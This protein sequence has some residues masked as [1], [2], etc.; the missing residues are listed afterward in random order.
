MSDFLTASLADILNKNK[1]L[2]EAG[3]IFKAQDLKD[4]LSRT[5]EITPPATSAAIK[6]PSFKTANLNTI[7]R[8]K[9][10]AEETSENSN[11][12]AIKEPN[13]KNTKLATILNRKSGA[14]ETPEEPDLITIEKD[15]EEATVLDPNLDWRQELDDRLAENKEATGSKRKSQAEVEKEFWNDF[16][17]TLWSKELIKPLH[18][19][20]AQFK[21]DILKWGFD[22]QSNDIIAFLQQEGIKNNILKN[23]LLKEK[24]YAVLH[25]AVI[26]GINT[27]KLR[28]S[29]LTK[30][31]TYNL[32]YNPNWYKLSPTEMT[33]YLELQQK[34]F[35][36]SLSA[37]QKVRANRLIFLVDPQIKKSVTNISEYIKEANK[38][39]NQ[40][41]TKIPIMRLDKPSLLN[42]FEE[43]IRIA[44]GLNIVGKN[45]KPEIEAEEEKTRKVTTAGIKNARN[46]SSVVSS[47]ADIHFVSEK[48]YDYTRNKDLL[49]FSTNIL[50][51][52]PKNKNRESVSDKAKAMVNKIIQLL[53]EKDIHFEIDF[54]ELISL[55]TKKLKEFSK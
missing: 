35:I 36:S 28:T 48:L 1:T 16:F 51:K 24:N 21:L 39:L 8:R 25:N 18:A 41:S 12:S 47:I 11:L 5:K 43:A 38:K 44:Q 4:I 13:F 54:T 15:E 42:S 10:G 40:S 19:L 7:L 22:A 17:V 2:T 34:V 30:V 31:N 46:I 6:N 26:G 33:K 45:Y 9:P 49:D 50:S 23:K 27:R 32:I 53:Q 20:G 52:Y 55:F 37:K 29:E 14:E 3:P